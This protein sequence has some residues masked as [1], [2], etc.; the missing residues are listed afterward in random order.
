MPSQEVKSGNEKKQKCFTFFCFCVQTLL[1]FKTL[2]NFLGSVMAV[3]FVG[4]DLETKRE[5]FHVFDKTL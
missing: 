3:I 2:R 5:N 4:T 1:R